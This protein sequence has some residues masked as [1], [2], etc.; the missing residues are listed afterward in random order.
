ML[1]GEATVK[2]YKTIDNTPYLIPANKKYK[3]SKIT[4]QHQIIGKVICL[5]RDI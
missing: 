5:F 4:E 3:K 1:E 2:Y